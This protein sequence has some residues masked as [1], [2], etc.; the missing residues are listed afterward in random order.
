VSILTFDACLFLFFLSLDV[1]ISKETE[2]IN[3][4]I[5]RKDES[6]VNVTLVTD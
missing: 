2:R 4:K 1:E 5:K 6:G 3:K